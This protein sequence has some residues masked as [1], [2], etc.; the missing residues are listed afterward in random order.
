[1]AGLPTELSDMLDNVVVMVEDWPDRETIDYYEVDTLYGLYQ[2][3]PL[4]ERGSNYYG[5]MPDTITI[6]RGPL[7]RDFGRDQLVE[8]VRV[9]VVHEIAHHFGLGE[10]RL[11][12]LGWA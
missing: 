10:E 8:Q 9:T 12:E 3:V 1:M 5:V 11:E 6:F 7:E 2:G 4:T